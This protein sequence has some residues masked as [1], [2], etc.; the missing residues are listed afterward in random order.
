MPTSR[1]NW[2]YHK[3]SGGRH[4][5]C[6]VG[7]GMGSS[8]SSTL[9]CL[10][11]AHRSRVATNRHGLGA[12]PGTGYGDR[13]FPNAWESGRP[14]LD[15]VREVL[16]SG[17]LAN[18]KCLRKTFGTWLKESRVDLR[19][20]QRLLRHHDPKL[21][22]NIYTDTRLP[23]L[24]NAVDSLPQMSHMPASEEVTSGD[25]AGQKRAG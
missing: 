10:H 4:G 17:G 20:A 13:H 24:Q 12:S 6:F 19:D 18:R 1:W 22:A 5:C 16:L 8:G 11:R 25:E 21:T 15:G 7:I 23:A 3:T 9:L 14:A 2:C